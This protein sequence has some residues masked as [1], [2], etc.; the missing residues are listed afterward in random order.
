E[1]YLAAQR[2][3]SRPAMAYRLV[4]EFTD[5]EVLRVPARRRHTGPTGAGPLH[6]RGGS[7]PEAAHRA[8]R[9]VRRHR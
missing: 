8:P 5:Y 2:R 6:G 7:G 9:T 3:G 1:A 4:H